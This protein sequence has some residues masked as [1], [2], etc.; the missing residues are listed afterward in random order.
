M[1]INHVVWGCL[2][3]EGQPWGRTSGR[4]SRINTFTAI[5]AVHGTNYA[6][7]TLLSNAIQV[8]QTFHWK[9]LS[10]DSFSGTATVRTVRSDHERGM[11]TE[12]DSYVAAWIEAE[13]QSGS[14]ERQTFTVLLGTDGNSY[15]DGQRVAI[16]IT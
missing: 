14:L 15:L 8:G 4:L 13:G 11:S 3:E 7:G 5:P 10:D 1:L 12:V 9:C 16:E 6:E 2:L